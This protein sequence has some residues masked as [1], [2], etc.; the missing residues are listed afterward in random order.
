MT[1]RTRVAP[2]PTGDPH[3]GTAYVALINYAYAK[4]NGGQFILRIE[5]TDRKR[6]TLASERM[7]LRS[8]HWLG[9]AWDEGPDI[10]GGNG[11]YRQSERSEIYQKY[12]EQLLKDGH[13]FRCYCT[14]ERLTAMREAQRRANISPRYDGHC[15]GLS[16]TQRKALDAAGTPSVVRMKIPA[17]GVCTVHDMRRGDIEIAWSTVD[18]QVLMKSDGMPTYHLANV[19]DDHLMGI[20]DVIRGEEWITSAPKHLA[21]Y[22]YF[23]W[24]APRI[25][26]LP[27]LRN[28]DHSKLSK[29]KN[30]TSILYYE[31]M[32]YLPEALLNFL[33]LLAVSLS[34]GEEVLTLDE[35]VQQFSLDNISLG[36]PVFDIKKLDWLNSR[37]IRE[38]HDPASLLARIEQWAVNRDYWQ[39]ITALAQPR[40]ERLSDLGPLT[41]F[42]FSGRLNVT[43]E[44]L[45]DTKLT[46]LQ[47]RQAYQVAL[48]QLDQLTSWEKPAIEETLRQ[49]SSQLNVKLRDLARIFYIAI[50]GS[51]QSVPLFDAMA[52]LGRDI[53]RERLRQALQTLG[54]VTSKE[55]DEW[56][57]AFK[58]K[59]AGEEA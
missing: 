48:W 54:P 27:L 26:H 3:L 23:G 40:I 5:D 2:S 35:F 50:T 31:R 52:L 59:D 51:H 6:S 15:L 9:L 44:A 18:M 41:A 11:P 47:Q 39:P 57:A 38:K 32:G 45:R 21:L 29:R 53:C 25:A 22:E 49:V 16:A 24:K 42:F 28:P 12:S 58:D 10:G 43:A 14:E 4:K 19:V 37:Y 46:E 13:A 55:A 1:V 30:P 36:G 7:I 56:R 8:L 17:D 33:G 34:E 20:T